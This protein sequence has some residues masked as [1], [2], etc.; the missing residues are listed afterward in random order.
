MGTDFCSYY[1][2]LAIKSLK[3]SKTNNKYKLFYFKVSKLVK[4]LKCIHVLNFAYTNTFRC[5][6]AMISTID[7]LR[8]KFVFAECERMHVFRI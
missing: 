1:S 5:K 3:K 7:Y 2:Y 6:N 4:P 8:S